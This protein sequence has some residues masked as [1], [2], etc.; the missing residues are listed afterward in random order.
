MKSNSVQFGKARNAALFFPIQNVTGKKNAFLKAVKTGLFKQLFLFAIMLL[1]FAATTEARP[2]DMRQARDLGAKFV[3]NNTNMRTTANDLRHVTTYS[4][5]NG[6]AA[7]YVFNTTNGFIIVAADDCSIPILAY[8]EEG[9]LNVNNIPVQMEEYLQVY[10]KEIEYGIEHRLDAD[11]STSLQWNTLRNTGT[12]NGTRTT[13]IVEPLLSTTWD[14][15]CYYNALC[16]EN[17]SS[18]QCGHTSTGTVATAMG[19]IMRYW[20]YPMV[21]SG[22]HSYT[23][24]GYPEQTAV[25]GATTYDWNNMPNYLDSLSTEEQINAVATLLWHCGVSVDLKYGSYEPRAF[26][27]LVPYALK[28]YFNY[29]DELFGQYKP[30]NASWLTQIE[31]N[32]DLGLPVYYS[33]LGTGFAAVCDGYDSNGCLHFNFGLSGTGNGY[34]PF[35]FIDLASNYS[36]AIFNIR[37]NETYQIVAVAEP[38]EGTTVGGGTYYHGQNCTLTATPAAGYVFA[39]WTENGNV[40]STD[41]HYTFTVTE[42][43]TLVANFTEV[44]VVGGENSQLIFNGITRPYDYL[45]SFS[46]F[47]YSLSEQI[48]TAEELGDAGSI[49]SIAFYNEGAEATR[50]YDIYLKHTTKSCFSDTTDWEPAF[51]S[52]RVFSGS[53]TMQA[54]DWTVITFDTPFDYDG[55]HRVV[56][57]VNDITGFKTPMSQM[58]SCRVFNTDENQALFM[59]S[60]YPGF[61]PNYPNYNP[62]GSSHL[63]SMKNQLLI[64]KTA[65]SYCLPSCSYYKYALSQQ[66]YTADELG[67]AGNISVIGFYNAGA[68]KTRT[69][70][71][72]MKPTLKDSFSYADWEIVSD[73]NLVFSGDVTMQANDWTY[74]T[75]DTPFAYDGNRNV[76]LVIDDNTGSYTTAPHMSCRVFN[77]SEDQAIFIYNNDI[78]YN[79]GSPASTGTM[80]S[81][82]NLLFVAKEPFFNVSVSVNPPEGGTVTGAGT[83]TQGQ[84]CIVTATANENEGYEFVNWTENDVMVSS[85][86]TYTFTVTGTRNLTANFQQKSYAINASANPT[87]GGTV[88]GG[89]TYSHGASCT[90]T[91]NPAAGFVFTN[92]TEN[93]E[94]V[95]SEA[96]YHFVVSSNHDLV[97]QFELDTPVGNIFFADTI[98]KALCVAPATNWDTN[99]DGELSYAEAAAVT[100]LGGVFRN[101]SSIKSF[102]ELQYFL[103][104]T[105]TGN[106]AFEQCTNLTS[107]ELPN[108]VTAIGIGA[109]R[110]CSGLTSIEIP[111]S[112]TSMGSGAFN[113]CTGLTSMTVLADNPPILANNVFH[114]V[115][116]SIPVYVPCGSLEAYQLAVGWNQFTNIQEVCTQTQTIE[117]V[118]GW[119]WFST[120]L[121]ITLD[122]LK[123]AL[124]EV[125]PGTNILIKSK[126][127]NTVYN[128]VTNQWRG[129]LNTLDLTQMYMISVCTN[130]E[131]I[132]T[133]TPINPTEHPITIQNG[134]NWIEFP[135]SENMSISNAFEGIVVNGDVI[136]SKTNNASYI[137]GQWR[138]N[139]NTLEPGKG[140]IY[141]SNSSEPK[142]LVY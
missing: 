34:Y 39:N 90:L 12:L 108:S 67:D 51:Y 19:Q 27:S 2:V 106:I 63:V 119:N 78:N 59:Y 56:L 124:I 45:P 133:G 77:T 66:I 42:D 103:G 129:T 131:I 113:N 10:L 36:Y 110:D 121:E 58:M 6:V 99:G 88:T 114:G 9:Q 86:T 134:F 85:D 122:E 102:D 57:V 109:F 8:S 24:P 139:F 23:P 91:A 17:H 61:D 22:I 107:I 47:K 74:I 69:Y 70:D 104:L 29:S 7:F 3:N 112:V 53:V 127:Q 96:S 33:G 30:N 89:G 28:E 20:Q 46:G 128:P 126:T 81:K 40:V 72:Y 125:A 68:E 76:V 31:Q 64:T 38:M 111:N 25:F 82:K 37:P 16:P 141:K 132:L 54:N 60:D 75:L 84:T 18:E 65:N 115:N 49:T 92:W 14:E 83:Y 21:G 105:F 62:N 94:V 120:N 138:G 32:L 97:A 93:G 5:S 130:C 98:V 1:G 48:Y 79:P 117:L 50:L 95:S 80:L 55:F 71:I 11:E 13:I 43:H 35:R 87:A 15:G 73:S 123:E 100:S 135:L 136:Q 118:A 140:Y 137:N 142:T 116:N 41:A 26:D 4:T 44:F 101:Q 52:D